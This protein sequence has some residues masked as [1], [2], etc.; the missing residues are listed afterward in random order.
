LEQATF[1]YKGPILYDENI[2]PKRIMHVHEDSFEDQD[3]ELA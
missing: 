2:A 3:T 1:A